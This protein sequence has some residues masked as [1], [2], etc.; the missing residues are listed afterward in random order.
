MVEAKEGAGVG[1]MD[2]ATQNASEMAEASASMQKR[3]G[4]GTRMRRAKVAPLGRVWCRKMHRQKLGG[5]GANCERDAHAKNEARGRWRED[6]GAGACV[7]PKNAKACARWDKSAMQKE[8]KSGMQ[9]G[10]ERAGERA[11]RVCGGLIVG[12]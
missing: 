9:K 5:R 3:R 7:V 11:E 1:G 2:G 10:L 6:G 4:C 8:G 12:V